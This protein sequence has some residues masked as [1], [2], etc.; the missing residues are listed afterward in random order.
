MGRN[1]ANQAT[2]R[3]YTCTPCAQAPTH[4]AAPLPPLPPAAAPALAAAL[5]A[6]AHS[7]LGLY[8]E[9]GVGPER[10]ILRLP[11][12][13]EGTQAAKQ[14]EAE[15]VA[16]QVRGGGEGWGGGGVGRGTEC[17]PRPMCW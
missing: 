4:A 12:T 9:L 5:V 16:T 8:R 3:T 1:G 14:L 15:G 13:W 11:A 7:L 6:K 2:G 10:L 17:C